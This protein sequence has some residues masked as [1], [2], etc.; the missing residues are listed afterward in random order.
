MLTLK[1]KTVIKEVLNYLKIL[2]YIDKITVDVFIRK[3]KEIKKKV[4][5]QH[6]FKETLS[7]TMIYFS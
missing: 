4:F 2:I 7:I 5:K 3:L 1:R 6:H